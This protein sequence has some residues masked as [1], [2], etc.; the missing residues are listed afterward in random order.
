MITRRKKIDLEYTQNLI[1]QGQLKASP[2]AVREAVRQAYSVVV[3]FTK[4]SDQ[5][6]QAL[7]LKGTAGNL[8]AAIREDTRLNIRETPVDPEALLARWFLWSVG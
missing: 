3:S 8:F 2:E 7:T 1:L 4:D 5:D 6:P